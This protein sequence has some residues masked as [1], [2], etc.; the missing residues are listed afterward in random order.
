M[1]LARELCDLFREL[2]VLLRQAGIRLE[3]LCEPVCLGLDRLHALLAELFLART[4]FFQSIRLQLV[5]ISLPR[6]REQDERRGVGSLERETEIQENERVDVVRRLRIFG[7][8]DKLKANR[9]KGA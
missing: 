2:L 9:S 1:N 5:S 4:M 7:Q 3:Q 6:L 8:R